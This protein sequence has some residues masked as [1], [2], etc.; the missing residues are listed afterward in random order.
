MDAPSATSSAWRSRVDAPAI[1]S[2]ARAVAISCFGILAVGGLLIV[3]RR[4]SGALVEPLPAGVLAGWAAFLSLAALAFR[5]IFPL[6][7]PC[8]RRAAYVFWAA[9][10]GV[11]MLW[12]T[13]LSAAGDRTGL[14]GLWGLMV[15]EEGWSWARFGR[16]LPTA[17]ELAPGRRF[18]APASSAEPTS[19]LVI[20]RELD[21][22]LDEK[23]DEAVWQQ[24][25]RRVR[26]DGTQAI[27]GWVRA[28][29]AARARHATA[30]VAICPPFDRAPECFAEQMAG[31][32]AQIKIAQVLA[33]GVRFEIKLDEPAD[34]PARV[35]VEFSI[36]ERAVAS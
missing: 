33:H 16:N 1:A 6:K 17:R 21:E 5:R 14:V 27:A 30:H 10:S 22:E 20:D 18:S 7:A 23:L 2:L 19:S 13:G 25:E 4:A 12:A 31:P 3:E 15:L 36:Q 26:E 32:S 11:L 35:L 34:E 9:T 28:D 29:V 8:G 24:F